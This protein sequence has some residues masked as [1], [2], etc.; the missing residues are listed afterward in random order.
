MASLPSQ[1]LYPAFYPARYPACT[2][3]SRRDFRFNVPNRSADRP[4]ASRT[5]EQPLKANQSERKEQE[6]VPLLSEIN[7]HHCRS[8]HGAQPNSDGAADGYPDRS[9]GLV[10]RTPTCCRNTSSDWLLGLGP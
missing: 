2:F 1:P 3:L 8:S 9:R 7:S 5:A 4:D 10:N 6:D